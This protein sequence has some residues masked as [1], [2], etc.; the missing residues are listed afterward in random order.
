TPVQEARQLQ[1]DLRRA[2]IEPFGWVI[3][4]SLAAAHPRDPLLA[5]RAAAETPRIE[6]VRS[7]AGRVALVPWLPEEPVGPAR[8]LALAAGR[9]GV[10]V[11]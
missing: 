8:L 10:T 3:N 2:G 9:E 1:D 5:A 4:S 7:L 11:R 6:L